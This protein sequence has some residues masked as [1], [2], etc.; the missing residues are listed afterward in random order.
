MGP[1]SHC[2]LTTARVPDK[3]NAYNKSL[4]PLWNKGCASFPQPS[5]I[6]MEPASDP[7]LTRAFLGKRRFY[8]QILARVSLRRAAF[9]NRLQPPNSEVDIIPSVCLPK[10][11]EIMIKVITAI[12]CSFAAIVMIILS[13]ATTYWL[14][15]VIISGNEN[16]THYRGLFYHCYEARDNITDE[17]IE[18]DCD[19]SYLDWKAGKY[20]IL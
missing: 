15:W 9:E 19:G 5:P 11:D 10:Q 3:P 4:L 1:F 18:E 14:Q 8:P 2:S 6:P 17:L 12:V 13:L 16:I 20:F 7:L